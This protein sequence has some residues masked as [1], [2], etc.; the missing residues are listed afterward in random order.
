MVSEFFRALPVSIRI[1]RVSPAPTKGHRPLE[2]M[3]LVLC[4][5]AT[6][7]QAGE[8]FGLIFVYRTDCAASRAFSRS[9]KAV[10]DHY[11]TAVLPV[12]QDNARF[13]EWP[14]TIPDVGQS[15][16]LNITR[17]PFLALFDPA[18]GAIAPITNR[19]LP[20]AQLEQRIAQTLE[21]FP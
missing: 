14:D 7:V 1:L 12:S 20:P 10:A 17:V 18:S 8:G 16:T 5:L 3:T 19:Y 2:T 11:G 13:A 15:E 6:P 9:V 21:Q 4:L